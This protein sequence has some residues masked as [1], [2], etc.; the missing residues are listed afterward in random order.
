[1]TTARADARSHNDYK[2]KRAALFGAARSSLTFAF[3]YT[4]G[5]DQTATPL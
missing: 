5:L 4:T 2:A 1:V 3:Q